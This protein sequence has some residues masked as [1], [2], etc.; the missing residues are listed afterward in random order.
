VI[1]H[2][3]G[4]GISNR[5]IGGPSSIA[6]LINGQVPDTNTVGATIPIGEQMG[7][8]WSDLYALIMTAQPTDTGNTPRGVGAYV[9]FQNENGPGIR[10]YP[11]TRNMKVNPFTYGDVPAQVAPH[12]VGS[13]WATMVWDL[14]WR[15]IDLHGY[16]PNLQNS[17]SQA[18]NVRTAALHQRRHRHHQVPPELRRF[19][20]RHPRAAK[21]VAPRGRVPDLADVRAARPRPARGQSHARRGPQAGARGLH[22][23]ADL[24]CPS[25]NLAPSAANDAY[26]TKRN[27]RVA[28]AAP[29]VLANDATR[30]AADHGAARAGSE[31]R[32]EFRAQGRRLVRL[33]AA[34]RIHRTRQLH[35]R[36]TGR[37]D[38]VQRG[39]GEHR[40]EEEI[41]GSA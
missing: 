37:T 10:L 17:A 3:Y 31:P 25:T 27:T 13:V 39:H 4:H 7:E 18:G 22:R 41:T 40:R 30:T 26:A 19:A 33:R 28:V 9:S 16:E 12:G 8:G 21:G 1:A 2:E 6:C 23:T 5:L 34:G 38:L 14:Y 29:G 15:M 24:R 11:Y 35:L 32:Q 20:Q 36:G